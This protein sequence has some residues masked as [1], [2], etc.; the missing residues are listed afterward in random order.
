MVN[1]PVGS[2]CRTVRLNSIVTGLWA[3]GNEQAVFGERLS[4][5]ITVSKPKS[6]PPLY[7]KLLL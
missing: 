1:S 6:H 5:A 7:E 2:G 4:R 3:A